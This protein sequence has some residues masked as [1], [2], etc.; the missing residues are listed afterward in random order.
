VSVIVV[1]VAIG[2]RNAGQR[3][4]RLFSR[5]RVGTRA[6]RY[7]AFISY[8]HSADGELASELQRNLGRF[9]VPRYRLRGRRIFRDET[10]LGVSETLWADIQ[11]AL[12]ASDAFILLA[13][14][15]SAQSIWV[16]REVD[17]WMTL[18]RGS[19]VLAITAGGVA[20]SEDHAMSRGEA[21]ALPTSLLAAYPE[22]PK[23]VDLRWVKT[24]RSRKPDDPRMRQAL[25]E[26]TARIEGRNLEQILDLD[27]VHRRRFAIAA[28]MVV[29]IM[30]V[31]L[32]WGI[33][34]GGR[35]AL[36]KEMKIRVRA[37]GL[38]AASRA[39]LADDPERGLL[40]A[41]EAYRVDPVADVAT[42]LHEAL[43]RSRVRAVMGEDGSGDVTAVSWSAT[44]DHLA[45]SHKNGTV[46]I[47]DAQGRAVATRAVPSHSRSTTCVCWSPDGRQL[48][49]A[50]EDGTAGVWSEDG[51]REASL[52]HEGKVWWVA[53]APDCRRLATA[54]GDHDAHIWGFDWK[55]PPI[56]LLGHGGKVAALAWSRDG[57]RLATGCSDGN[58]RLWR[59]DGTLERTLAGHASGMTVSSVAF[60]HDGKRLATACWDRTVRIWDLARGVCVAVL[61]THQAEVTA[62]AW[63]R[64][65]RRIAS[66]SSDR[67]ARIWEFTGDQTRELP[68]LTGHHGRVWG[69][70]WSPD[71]SSLATAAEDGLARIW[72]VHGAEELA[73]ACCG[74]FRD[75]TWSPTGDRFASA[76]TDGTACIWDL[77]GRRISSLDHGNEVWCVAWSPSGAR[78]ATASG[79]HSA[80]IWLLDGSS[81]SRP[82]GNHASWVTSVEWCPDETG[83]ATACYDGSATRWSIDGD[84]GT[85][86]ADHS[87]SHL[88]AIAWSC[89]GRI[90]TASHDHTARIWNDDGTFKTLQHEQHGVAAAAWSPDGKRLATGSWDTT[91]RIW[92][93]QGDLLAVLRGHDRG[94]MSVSWSRDGT[95]I[96]TASGDGTVRIWSASEGKERAVLRGT[97]AGV[98]AVAWS[99]DGTRIASAGAD[100]LILIWLTRL[101]DLL[102]LAD[103]RL[104]ATGRAFSAAERDRYASLLEVGQE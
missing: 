6:K 33:Y 15:Q 77:A 62:V 26:I 21:P 86:L 31:L 94:V 65:D 89:D 52:P 39:S 5:T 81:D 49:T 70:A 76:S 75:V 34:N 2:L 93:A 100:G 22:T 57:T 50:S 1:I 23:W 96:A 41:R 14:P 56:T 88:F 102:A 28:S 84:R 66:A 58:T 13:S 40:L 48:A 104:A 9:A 16:Q 3:L 74:E 45:T 35:A 82:L 80:R 46:G 27:A 85:D 25:A 98:H 17:Y 18:R 7:V 10:G 59:D 97:G 60:S 67:T 61:V 72:R 53:W 54:S 71:G 55:G 37:L 44:T 91:A 29:A 51:V 47:W 43:V 63:S 32:G 8:S 73:V 69:I 4:R 87:G 20:W 83:L 92:S 30:A 38:L 90:A 68:P 95:M 24:E 99:P 36:E 64:D 12:D 19:P 101:Q 11:R 78:L 103:R 42:T 79:D